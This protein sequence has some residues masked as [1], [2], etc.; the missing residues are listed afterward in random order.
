M[1]TITSSKGTKALNPVICSESVGENIYEENKYVAFDRI[2]LTASS[3]ILETFADVT[4]VVDD[5]FEVVEKNSDPLGVDP[6][7]G[8]FGAS[9]L[10]FAGGVVLP[11]VSK[12]P[13][14][15]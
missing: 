8:H 1:F 5:T 3:F 14:R 15:R 11:V 12:C 9:I 2:A 6:S 7:P 10:D 13:Q 4:K